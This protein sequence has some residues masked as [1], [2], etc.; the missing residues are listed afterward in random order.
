[1][2]VG[3]PLFISPNLYFAF[4]VQVELIRLCEYGFGFGYVA[5][6][7]FISTGFPFLAPWHSSTFGEISKE[8]KYSPSL[9]LSCLLHVAV[10]Y[11][12]KPSFW[13]L[14]KSSLIGVN[15]IRWS[16]LGISSVARCYFR[17]TRSL[18]V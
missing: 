10:L 15:Y 18:S 8:N 1:M 14:L 17:S 16:L 2:Q 6:R 5:Y 12:R 9:P 11:G 13:K 7:C 3:I 4:N